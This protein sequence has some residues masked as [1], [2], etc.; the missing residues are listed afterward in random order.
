MGY[1]VILTEETD[2]LGG[3]LTSQMVPPDEHRYI[4]QFGCT[5]RYRSLRDKIRDYYRAHY[6]LHASAR[7]ERALNP[8]GGTVAALCFE[9]RV[10]VEAIYQLLAPYLVSG[11]VQVLTG[12]RPVAAQ[13]SGDVVSS[14]L[15]QGQGGGSWELQADYFLDAT[16]L[17]D[18]LPLS[19]AEYVSGSE[20]QAQTGEPHA[21]PQA[22]PDNVQAFTWCAVIAHDPDCPQG[23]DRYRI[24]RPRNY[25]KWRDTIPGMTPPWP[26]PLLSWRHTHPITS[27]PVDRVLFPPPLDNGMRPL[28]IYRQIVQP[29]IYDGIRVHAATVVN[30]PQNDYLEGN[31][32]DTTPEQ[33]AQ[34]LQGSRE[35]TL[36]LIHW[37]QTEAPRPDGGTGYA[38]IYL[39]PDLAGTP[40]G[41]AKAPYIR[42][43]RRMRGLFTVSENHIGKEARQGRPAE[44]F[45]D[46]VGIGSYRIDLHPSASGRNYLDIESLPFQIPLGSLI[47][48]RVKNLLAAGKTVSVTHIANGCYR[49]HPVEWNIGEAAGA[50]AAFCLASKQEPQAVYHS[51]GQTTEFQAELVRQGIELKWPWQ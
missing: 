22:E 49:L 43:A 15:C 11:Q 48:R 50:L 25:E 46:S 13:V 21:T 26:S 19:G 41:L 38:G 30:W 12:C 9:P 5:A 34:S 28:W 42:E 6:P 37:M 32:I 18:L 33:V 36:S 51:Q 40:D 39:R 35:L 27:Q 8:G 16:E 10:A 20:S 29:G 14:V 1:R 17:G 4:E 23:C 45:R 31:L 2:W 3:Q 7:A 47:H 44:V 24:E